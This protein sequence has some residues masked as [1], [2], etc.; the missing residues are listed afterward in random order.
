MKKKIIGLVVSLCFIITVL[1]VL[2]DPSDDPQTPPAPDTPCPADGSTMVTTFA[3]LG[4][5]SG[6][7]GTDT[8]VTYDV[9]FGT[10]SPPPNVVRN[11]SGTT[12]DPGPLG[13]E[14]TYYWQIVA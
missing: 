13:F 14:T 9:C 3:D 2:G 5:N 1:P 11:Y 12:F 6:D 4:W 8:S 10:E 7:A